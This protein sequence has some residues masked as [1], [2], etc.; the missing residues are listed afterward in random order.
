MYT[1]DGLLKANVQFGSSKKVKYVLYEDGVEVPGDSGETEASAIKLSYDLKSK[2]ITG[3]VLK[4]V[5]TDSNGAESSASC[6]VKTTD[7]VN[8]CA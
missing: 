4:I 3:R 6:K 7:G 2:G 5:V 8:K 1:N